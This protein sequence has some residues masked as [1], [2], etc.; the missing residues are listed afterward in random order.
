[1]LESDSLIC[2][3]VS[4]VANSTQYTNPLDCP[5]NVFVSSLFHGLKVHELLHLEDAKRDIPVVNP[6]GVEA[7][8]NVT[9]TQLNIFPPLKNIICRASMIFAL[10]RRFQYAIPF[11]SLYSPQEN[12]S[13]LGGLSGYGA[14]IESTGKSKRKRSR[15]RV[16]KTFNLQYCVQWKMYALTMFMCVF[17][18]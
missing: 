11:F 6:A 7:V 5:L 18:I 9:S 4:A 14:S 16:S 8:V 2:R 12:S 1:M 10:N 13:V 17:F 15:E 3:M